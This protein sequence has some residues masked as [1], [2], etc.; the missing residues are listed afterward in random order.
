MSKYFSGKDGSAPPLEKLVRI[1]LC[2]IRYIGMDDGHH[3]HYHH[4]HVR[5]YIIQVDRPQVAVQYNIVV[6]VVQ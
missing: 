6:T 2:I 3:H 4:H 5:L 1:P